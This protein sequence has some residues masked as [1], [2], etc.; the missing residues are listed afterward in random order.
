MSDF[1]IEVFSV[2]R[3]TFP[4]W[5]FF[6]CLRMYVDEMSFI[7]C[8]GHFCVQFKFGIPK[9]QTSVVCVLMYLCLELDFD[10]SMYHLAKICGP[11]PR[12]RHSMLSRVRFGKVAKVLSIL[13]TAQKLYNPKVSTLGRTSQQVISKSFCKDS[14]KDFINLPHATSFQH[15]PDSI[16]ARAAIEVKSDHH[17][18][19]SIY[20]KLTAE[21]VVIKSIKQIHEN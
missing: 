4:L 9:G 3:F 7:C 16:D 2:L 6:Y 12:C 8:Q 5:T 15:Y 17:A 13:G 1:S 11:R 21:T 19:A 14:V 10:Q 18:Q 20:P